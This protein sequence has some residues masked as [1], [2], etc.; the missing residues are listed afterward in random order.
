MVSV[1]SSVI[2]PCTIKYRR[3][4]LLALAYPGSSRKRDVTRL[5]VCVC[6]CDFEFLS[7]CLVLAATVVKHFYE[8][9][10]VL[11]EGELLHLECRT[12]GFPPPQIRW[13]RQSRSGDNAV[14]IVTGERV[15][16]D[17]FENVGN[18]SLKIADVSVEDYG[19]YTC[20]AQNGIGNMS[21]SEAILIRVKGI[22]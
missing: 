7:D 19:T 16:L 8:K 6:V 18:A 5:C 1:S 11:V 3:R 22:V 14:E 9:S 20:V 2:F 17:V 13:T 21:D 10:K 4:F 12:W 15:S